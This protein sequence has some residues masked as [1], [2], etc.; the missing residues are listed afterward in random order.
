[1]K[2]LA[3][4]LLLA[5]CVPA[6]PPQEPASARI[7][8]FS[9]GLRITETGGQEIGFGREMGGAVLA[10][11]KILPPVPFPVATRFDQ[12]NCVTVAWDFGLTMHFRN[13]TFIGWSTTPPDFATAHAGQ[14]CSN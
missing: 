3:V 10:V 8:P 1:M 11:E 7:V 2:R 13:Q 14:L 5:A 6:D 9:G 12:S 4:I